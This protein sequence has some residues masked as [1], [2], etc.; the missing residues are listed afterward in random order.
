MPATLVGSF[1]HRTVTPE[2]PERVVPIRP[3]MVE[4]LCGL[5]EITTAARL[6]PRAPVPALWPCQRCREPA[7]CTEEPDED[8]E[9]I[10]MPRVSKKLPAKTHWEQLSERRSEEELQRILDDR[11]ARLRAGTLRSGPSYL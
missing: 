1:P 8:A 7:E 4:Y 2:R 6:H 3:R 5:C 10:G 11:L 9:L